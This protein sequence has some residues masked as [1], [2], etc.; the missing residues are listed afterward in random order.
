MAL[1]QGLIQL[2]KSKGS[3]TVDLAVSFTLGFSVSHFLMLLCTEHGPDSPGIFELR[4]SPVGTYRLRAPWAVS[5]P[6]CGASGS[7][8]EIGVIPL[9]GFHYFFF[10]Q[11]RET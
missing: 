11:S 5:R 10:A 8:A 6:Y 1:A 3:K 7:Q 9:L 4:F 2:S